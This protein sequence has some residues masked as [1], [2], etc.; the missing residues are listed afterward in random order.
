[1]KLREFFAYKNE[2][3]MCSGTLVTS[4]HSKRKQK[5]KYEDNRFVVEFE[6]KSL[7]R[8]QKDYKAGYSLG[9]DDNSFYAEFYNDKDI[10]FENETQQ[11]LIDRFKELNKNLQTFR[12][13]KS[14]PKCER[15]SYNSNEFL[16]DYKGCTIGELSLDVEASVMVQP[17]TSG[18]K[19]YKMVNYLRTKDTW[20][21][22]GK[23]SLNE[24]IRYSSTKDLTL[25]KLSNIDLPNFIQ[26]PIIPFTT[27]DETMNRISKLLIFS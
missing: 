11:F 2:C 17:T 5:Y 21:N 10:R 18:Y 25:F 3:P 20:L 15:Y 16:I 12:F 6:L 26:T 13:Y 9:L 19:I 1:M 7:N 8:K 24:A 23:I 27:H 22:Y 14:C 4:F